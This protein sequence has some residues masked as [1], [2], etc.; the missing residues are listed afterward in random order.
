LRHATNLVRVAEAE[1]GDPGA[2]ALDDD[3]LDELLPQAASRQQ[4]STQTTGSVKFLGAVMNLVLSCLGAS[5]IPR[6]RRRRRA[7]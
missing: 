7:S 1:A 4:A 5:L 2:A 6:S 3:E